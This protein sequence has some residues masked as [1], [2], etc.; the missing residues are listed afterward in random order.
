[1]RN[2]M[3]I[4]TATLF[5]GV[6]VLA[7]AGGSPEV[8][9]TEVSQSAGEDETAAMV[10]AELESI[11]V[12]AIRRDI[13][14]EDFSLA[15]LGGP[16]QTLE[17]YSGRMVLLNFW[18]TWCAP[19]VKEI[20]AFEELNAKY[21]SNKVKVLLV[22][23]D[24]PNQVESRVLPFMDRMNIQ[25]QVILLDDP[26]SNR[27]IGKVSEEWSGA[28]PATVIYSSGFRGFYEREFTFEE[29]EEIIK[30]LIK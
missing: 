18:A 20:P 21:S 24:F 12:Q 4:A 15:T 6:A 2:P 9:G 7:A 19:C 17:D 16:N 1:M 23:L 26:Y 8:N 28:I 30:P 22:S 14:A 3:T 29:L 27:W 25:S 13:K 5:L 10:A 11:G